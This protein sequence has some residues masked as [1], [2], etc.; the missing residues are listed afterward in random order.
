M[1]TNNINAIVAFE[2]FITR[3]ASPSDLAGSLSAILSEY[4]KLKGVHQSVIAETDSN[5]AVCKDFC[6]TLEG[7]KG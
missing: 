3:H 7:N 1:K 6:R 4:A 2:K 5:F